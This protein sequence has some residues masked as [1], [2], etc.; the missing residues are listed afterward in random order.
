MILVRP[1]I[2]GGESEMDDFQGP[3][4]LFPMVV[5]L[6]ISAFP[7]LHSLQQLLKLLS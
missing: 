2:R 5:V 7:Y 4:H 6:Q 3:H 1:W